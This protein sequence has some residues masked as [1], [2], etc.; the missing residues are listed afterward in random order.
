MALLSPRALL[1]VVFLQLIAYPLFAQDLKNRTEEMYHLGKVIIS[2]EPLPDKVYEAQ[3]NKFLVNIIF[4]EKGTTKV[5]TSGLATG[6]VADK[7]GVILTARH[8]LIDSMREMD[9]LK[10]ERI[11]TNPQFDYDYMFMGT[12][13]TPTAWINFPLF[14]TAVGENGTMK[15]IMALRTDLQ[16]MTLAHQWGDVITPNPLSILLRTFEFVDANLGEKVYISGFAPIVGEVPN[17]NKSDSSVYVDLINFTFLGEVVAKIE[18]M[19]VNNNGP[20]LIYRLRDSAEPGFSGGLVLNAK[21]QV[22]GI[23]MSMSKNFIYIV[24]S[25]DLKDFL[26]EN[27]LK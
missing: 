20:D 6:F 16:T 22:L 10:T 3:K 21:G 25:K 1:I 11:K 19:P 12:I 18:N 7:P 4:L 23:T 27:K 2:S 13:I 24:S 8:L 17:K 9:L 5:L 14:L 26:K 15:D